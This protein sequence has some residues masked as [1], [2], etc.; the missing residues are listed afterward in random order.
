MVPEQRDAIGRTPALA[1]RLDL[2]RARILLPR[3]AEGRDEL[4]EG[5]RAG[6]ADVSAIAVYRTLPAEV[7]AADLRRRLVGGELHALT[8]TSPS[9]V[10]AFAALLDDPARAAA[11]RCTVAAIGSTTAEALRNEGLAPD[12]VPERAG[13]IELAEALAGFAASGSREAGGGSA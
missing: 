1:E 7:D 12:L 9:A 2:A 4:V 10:S 6:G 13:S 5:L 3:A 8:F 11:A